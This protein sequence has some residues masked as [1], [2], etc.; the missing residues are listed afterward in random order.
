MSEYV[1]RL[2]LKDLVG[3]GLLTSDSELFRNFRK[4]LDGYYKTLDSTE[5]AIFVLETLGINNGINMGSYL[6]KYLPKIYDKQG[7]VTTN[8]LARLLAID[9]VVDILLE[10]AKVKYKEDNLKDKVEFILGKKL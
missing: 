2:V 5:G 1:Q 10:W 3:K 8:R 9:L 6:N 4:D 7:K